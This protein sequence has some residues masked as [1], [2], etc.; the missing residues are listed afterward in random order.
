MTLQ[1]ALI[2]LF[3]I[4][5][6]AWVWWICR[7]RRPHEEGFEYVYVNQD[8]TVRELASGEVESLSSD[9][10]PGDSGRPYIKF[11]YGSK[12]GWG[13]LSGFILRRKVPRHIKIPPVNPNYK[14]DESLSRDDL[15]Q[16]ALADGDIVTQNEDGSV[17]IETNPN[18]SPEERYARAREG[19]LSQQAAREETARFPKGE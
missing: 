7:R 13:S 11:R 9:F 2:A 17:T 6:L 16:G 12:D 19:Q 4:A 10:L 1:Q 15:I 8:G 14:G 5:L 3:A 18:L